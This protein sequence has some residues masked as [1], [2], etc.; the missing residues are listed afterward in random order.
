MLLIAAIAF[1]AAIAGVFVGRALLPDRSHTGAELHALLHDE[2]TLDA[3][4]HAKLDAIE[5]AFALR[6]TALEREMRAENAG[7]AEAIEAEHGYG[8][9]VAAAI[10]ASHM[11]MGQLQRE[12]LEH[13][14]ASSRSIAS[15]YVARTI[16]TA[17]VSAG[18]AAWAGPA[19]AKFASLQRGDNRAS[20]QRPGGRC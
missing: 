3:A 5:R 1:A 2:V 12:T 20:G 11:T 18:P 15:R 14:L 16:S 9:R 4:Q 17:R 7:L 8:P 19:R 13:V 10:D 6:R